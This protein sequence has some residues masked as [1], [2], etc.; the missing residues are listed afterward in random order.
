MSYKRIVTLVVAAALLMSIG[1]LSPWSNGSLATNSQSN[2]AIACL[3]SGASAG[4][5]C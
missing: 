3:N 2:Q 4:G 1:V 5:G